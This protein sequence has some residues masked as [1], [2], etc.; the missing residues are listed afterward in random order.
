MFIAAFVLL[1]FLIPL[2]YLARE[3]TSDERF[4]WRGFTWS[5]PVY[6]ETSASLERLDGTEE[7]IPLQ[8]L[9]HRDWIDY[10]G[11]GRHAVVDAFLRKQCEA[12]GVLQVQLVNL[13]GDERF[14]REYTLRCGG[15]QPHE[16]VR[17]AA[18]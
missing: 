16:V 15:E 17:T 5:E 9:I 1:Q 13:C 14:T 3:D 18:R 10:V 12:E 4:T 7:P 8:R 6:C 11:Q 2:T